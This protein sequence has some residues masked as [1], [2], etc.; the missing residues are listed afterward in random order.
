MR[1]QLTVDQD[2]HRRLNKV[3]RRNG[4]SLK[5]LISVILTHTL[6]KLESGEIKVS[7]VSILVEAEETTLVE[8]E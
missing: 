5:K 8:S 6:P 4:L 7:P 1:K 2:T 3:A